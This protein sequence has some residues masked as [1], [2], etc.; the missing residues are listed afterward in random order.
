MHMENARYAQDI[1][2]ADLC[3]AHDEYKPYVNA[4]FSP[5]M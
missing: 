1:Y 2:I 5:H 3:D 4:F